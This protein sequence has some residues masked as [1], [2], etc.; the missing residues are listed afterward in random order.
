VGND[1]EEAR[2]VVSDVIDPHTVRASGKRARLD[3]GHFAA[4]IGDVTLTYLAYGAEVE[5]AAPGESGCFC[6]HVPLAGSASV[7]C[8]ADSMASTPR[9]AS[10]P[11]AS[12]SLR[13]I[14]T[15]DAEH[16][17]VRIDRDA[18]ARQL[19]HLA[20]GELAEP[21]RTKLALDLSGVDGARWRAL[22][23]LLQAEIAH[24]GA[25]SVDPTS[26]PSAAAVEE[27]TLNALLLWHPNNYWG[28]LSARA[29][30]ASAPYVRRALDYIEGHLQEPL[31][32]ARLAEVAGVSIRALQAGFIRDLERPPTTY[33]RDLR[34][35]RVRAELLSSE[36]LDTVTDVAL[37][38]GFSHLGRFSQV[39]QDR[40]GEL[41]SATLRRR[42]SG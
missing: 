13:M 1:L 25:A 17:I 34:L 42:C 21:I 14:W 19:Q 4:R 29:Q 8:G 27:M 36:E 16:L 40:F 12:E 20:P 7:H 33:V 41:P 6:V 31:T 5:I 35:D 24:C 26:T 15:A 11:T 3:I 2:A 18:V 23:E 10:V 28:R 38:W 30:P 37:R 9:A 32:V 22:L 39:Y